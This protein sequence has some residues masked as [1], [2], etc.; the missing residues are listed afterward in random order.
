[1]IIST[2]TIVA[3]ILRSAI[4]VLMASKNSLIIGINQALSNVLEERFKQLS[5]EN[6]S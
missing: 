3:C 1:M 4:A 5:S 6:N 2:M